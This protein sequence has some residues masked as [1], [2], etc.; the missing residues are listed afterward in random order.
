ME[1]VAGLAEDIKALEKSLYEKHCA[2]G[3]AELREIL[4]T[5]DGDLAEARDKKRFRLKGKRKTSIRTIMGEV[6]IT[7][8]IYLDLAETA[9][10]VKKHVFLL[11]ES[12]GMCTIGKMS[13]NLVERAVDHCLGVSFREAAGIVGTYTSQHVS[14]QAIWNVVQKAGSR[15]QEREERLVRE[16]RMEETTG[17][18]Q[19]DV[20]FEEADGVHLALQRRGQRGGRRRSAE[21]KVGVAYEGWEKRHPRASRYQR[22]GKTVYA[23]FLGGNEFHRTRHAIV[24]STYDLDEVKVRV[25]GGDGARWIRAG[26]DGDTEIFQLD[27]YH[28]HRAVCRGVRDK[29]ACSQ[30]RGWV[31]SG[32]TDRALD[33]LEDLKWE[34]GG[35]AE[36]VKR[37]ESL[38]EYLDA[39]RDGLVPWQDR[40]G[41][42]GIEAPEGL[43]YRNLGT[44]ERTVELF[45]RR[46]DGPLS[47]SIP[48]ATHMAKLLAHK[49]SGTLEEALAGIWEHSGSRKLEQTA[50][51]PVAAP[52]SRRTKR[53]LGTRN[54]SWQIQRGRIP[55]TDSSSTVGRRIIRGLFNCRGLGDIG[56]Q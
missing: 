55:Y 19:V 39:N 53:R 52:R 22:V 5:A 12:L 47:W 27:P 29:K 56:F 43:E 6:E 42:E 26:A 10:G 41:M 9:P 16:F 44:V 32:Q 35:L 3:R 51:V 17:K 30:I 24:G 36:E 14:H 28:L 45:D 11:D 2:N 34:C 21:L 37:L 4:E 13:V 40:P 50:E 49:A 31:R 7:R 23:G 18:R 46:M 54:G 20:L 38:R 25:L 33:V 15:V 8:R 48:G 1:S